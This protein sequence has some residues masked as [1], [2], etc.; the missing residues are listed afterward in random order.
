ML[1]PAGRQVSDVVHSLTAVAS[2]DQ[3]KA[4]KFIDDFAPKGA[5]AQVSGVVKELPVA[6]G[7]YEELMSF[8]V[9]RCRALPRSRGY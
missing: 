2:R 9:R 5:Y 1:D 8:K 6:L 7:S 3:S 4:Q